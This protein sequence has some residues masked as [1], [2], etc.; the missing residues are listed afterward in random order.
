MAPWWRSFRQLMVL[1]EEELLSF[2]DMDAG[3][4]PV[5]WAHIY[6]HVGCTNGLGRLLITTTKGGPEVGWEVGWGA[7]AS[8]RQRH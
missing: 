2:V 1:R 6:A 8:V 5:L 3:T 4:L 7:L